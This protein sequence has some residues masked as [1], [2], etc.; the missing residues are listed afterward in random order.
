[1]TRK[2]TNFQVHL[3]FCYSSLL[4]GGFSEAQCIPRNSL[5]FR[6]PVTVFSGLSATPIFNNLTT[7]RGITINSNQNLLVVE[8][9][10]GVTAFKENDSTCSNGWLRTI[11]IQNTEFTHRIQVSGES[12]YVSTDSEILR[13]IYDSTTRTVIGNPVVIISGIPPG[14]ELTTRPFLLQPSTDPTSILASCPLSENIDPTARDP[15]SGRSQIRSF[16]LPSTSSPS[17]SQD[18]FSGTLLAFGIRNPAGFAFHPLDSSLTKLWIIDNGASIGNVTGLT[19]TF[20]N[21][22]PAD[23]LNV[24]EIQKGKENNFFGFPDCTTIWNPK[25]DPTGDPQFINFRTGEQFSLQLESERDDEWCQNIEN[26]IPPRL[27]FQAHSAPLDLKFFNPR[28]NVVS[29]TSLPM[30]WSGDAFVSFHGSFDRTPP[31][32]YGVVRVPFTSSNPT[33]ISPPTST[34]GYDFVIQT[35]D[36]DTCPGTCIRPVGLVFESDGRLFV[37]SDSSGELFVVSS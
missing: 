30:A 4:L 35:T 2:T 33:P 34:N 15:N 8:R 20:V 29:Q 36:L 28:H 13:Y 11:V 21:D 32:G 9:G 6:S 7:P 26:N 17:T 3:A 18:F 14:G 23:E 22:N 16:P 1:M 31:T 5:T 19:D 12:L 37:T 27:S 10:F 25:V 24:A